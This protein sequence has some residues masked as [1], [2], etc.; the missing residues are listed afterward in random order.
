M[1]DLEGTEHPTMQGEKHPTEQLAPS[2]KAIVLSSTRVESAESLFVSLFT[3]K[4]S[5]LKQCI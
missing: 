2:Q 3:I 1:T 5:T 4:T